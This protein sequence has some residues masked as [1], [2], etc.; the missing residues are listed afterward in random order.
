VKGTLGSQGQTVINSNEIRCQTVLKSNIY[1]SGIPQADFTASPLN[2][3]INGTVIFTDLSGYM[4]TTWQ[5]SF[6][7]L[8]VIYVD[9]TSSVSQNPHVQFTAG[10]TYS[11][12]LTVSNTFGTG[13]LTKPNYITVSL[14]PPPSAY[15]TANKTN[16][17]TG[18]SVQFIDVTTGNP[19]SWVWTFEGG[20]PAIWNGQTP[21]LIQYQSNGT[22]DVSLVASNPYGSSTKIRTD[23]IAV[24]SPPPPVAGFTGNPTTLNTGGSVQ[25]TDLSSNNPVSWLWT[26]EGGVPSTSTSATPPPV[27][28]NSAGQFTV[29]L[30]VSNASG[31]DTMNKSGYINVIVPVIPSAEFTGIPAILY[32]GGQVQFSDLSTGSPGSWQWIFDGGTPSS[33][34]LQTPPPITYSTSGEYDVTLTV[35][36]VNGNSTRKK[37]KYITVINPGGPIAKFSGT[38]TIV[39]I[40]NQVQFADETTG[41]PTTWQWT[42]EGGVPGSFDGQTPPPVTYSNTGMYDVSLKVTN[43]F[44]TH[45]SS[46][47]DYISVINPFLPVAGFSGDKWNIVKGDS[48]LFTDE[49]TGYPS[50]WS[51]T[52]EGGTPSVS[53]EKSPPPIIYQYAGSYDV[54]LIVT[55]ENGSNTMLKSNYISVGDIGMDEASPLKLMIYPN[56]VKDKVFFQANWII[57]DISIFDVFGKCTVKAR[58]NMKSGS[59]D[60]SSLIPGVYILNIKKDRQELNQKIV[61]Q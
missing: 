39:N 7:P 61:I 51:W 56:P 1:C 15:F 4:P 23:Y 30:I 10:G 13:S 41:V 59:I 24:T 54:T 48:I 58:I 26:F 17:F 43:L 57:P 42:F 49:S 16:I 38:P 37:T 32:S 46:I 3:M 60:L 29:S 36:N 11:V 52:F 20:T 28:Y 18:G 40:G 50:S 22:F 6:S 53:H 35:S 21:P 33:S 5:W 31:S 34:G 27:T 25:F 44:G 55:N 47:Q 9:G 19:T 14:P 8:S 45:T 2:P 12:S